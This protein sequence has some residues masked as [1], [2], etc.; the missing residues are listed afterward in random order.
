[1]IARFLGLMNRTDWLRLLGF[2]ALTL[3]TVTPW[4]VVLR[5]LLKGI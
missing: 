5:L 4:L 3:A 1:M 2:Y